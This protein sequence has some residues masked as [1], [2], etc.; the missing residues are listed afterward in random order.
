MVW[1]LQMSMK[2]KFGI[3]AIFGTGAFA[4][5]LAIVRIY[6][7]MKLLHSKDYT[8][9]HMQTGLLGYVTYGEVACGIICSCLPL[10]P[11]F[12]HHLS[13]SSTSSGAIKLD[14]INP[15]VQTKRSVHESYEPD[16]AVRAGTWVK[17]DDGTMTPM[18][19]VHGVAR[20]PS[21]EQA[22]AHAIAGV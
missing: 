4:T 5:I 15:K 1:K 13:H 11:L 2:R 19:K 3:S 9:V 20:A 14:N 22:L 8:F 21:D 17:L 16:S 10:L 18:P 12:W 6:F 7:Q